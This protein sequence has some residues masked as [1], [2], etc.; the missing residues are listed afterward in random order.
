GPVTHARYAEVKAA[1]V[2]IERVVVPEVA[3][4]I[5]RARG[6]KSTLTGPL[7]ANLSMIKSVPDAWEGTVQAFRTGLRVPLESELKLAA[8]NEANPEAAGAKTPYIQ[9]TEP[10]WGIWKKVFN[11][12]QLSA[13]ARVLGIP[14]R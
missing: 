7:W 3:A 9:H 6:G 5:D 10:E 11:E 4:I 1:T 13:A 14:G 12:D 8:R 2:G